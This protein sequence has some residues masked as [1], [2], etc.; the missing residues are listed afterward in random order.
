MLIFWTLLVI[1]FINWTCMRVSKY[2]H[3][4]QWKSHYRGIKT[5]FFH[6][7]QAQF[8]LNYGHF[9]PY[10]F[11]IRLKYWLTYKQV[12]MVNFFFSADKMLIIPFILIFHRPSKIKL[13]C[14]NQ[15]KVT[16]KYF[17]IQLYK[18]YCQCFDKW[19][20][21][22]EELYVRIRDISF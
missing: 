18:P 10:I 16:Q 9:L 21:K 4:I 7:K 5:S 17:E 13:K 22:I 3:K 8:F 14:I 2:G 6:L 19:L 11:L 20:V 15:I 12:Y 1:F